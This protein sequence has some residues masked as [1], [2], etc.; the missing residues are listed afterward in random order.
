[1]NSVRRKRSEPH[2]PIR[3]LLFCFALACGYAS[4]ASAAPPTDADR[5]LAQPGRL[6]ML[7]H[8]TAPGLGDPPGFV[9]G[10]CTTQRNLSAEG[11]AQAARLG[12]RLRAAGVQPARI[13][14]SQWCRTLDTARLLDLGA[15]EANPAL[16]SFFEERSDR[17][18]VLKA[19]RALLATLPQDGPPVIMVTHQVVINAFTDAYPPSGGGSVFRLNGSGTPQWLGILAVD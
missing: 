10:D 18:A 17:D 3:A 1:M 7:R 4:A 12:K 15:V 11:R 16:N 14:S 13:L 9:L 2:M 8:A 19:L 5:D 6:I